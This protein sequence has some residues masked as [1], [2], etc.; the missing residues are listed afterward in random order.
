MPLFI[1]AIRVFQDV[2]KTALWTV[3][4]WTILYK[5]PK[6]HICRLFV[7]NDLQE[8]FPALIYHPI[9]RPA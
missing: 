2:I 4:A 6:Q 7:K 9:A 1:F 3:V 8:I 5:T